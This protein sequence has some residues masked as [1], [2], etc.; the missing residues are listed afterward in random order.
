MCE[1]SSFV[2]SC[3]CDVK[4][5][6]MQ[7]VPKLLDKQETDIKN[8][9]GLYFFDAYRHFHIINWNFLNGGT[10]NETGVIMEWYSDKAVRDPKHHWRGKVRNFSKGLSFLYTWKLGETW[11]F[12]KFFHWGGGW[13]FPLDSRGLISIIIE[14]N[15]LEKINFMHLSYLEF[16]QTV[17]EYCQKL[18][19]ELAKFKKVY[20]Q[21]NFELFFWGTGKLLN[22]WFFVL[23]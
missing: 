20:P 5:D 14:K 3:K 1:N 7:Q 9:P 4:S 23:T 12:S 8:S 16:E 18:I 19:F 6:T 2:V 22:K 13:N 15:W 11:H 21:A 17:S 10:W